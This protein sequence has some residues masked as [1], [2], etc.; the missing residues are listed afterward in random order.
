MSCTGNT[1]KWDVRATHLA[2]V[3]GGVIIKQQALLAVD[4]SLASRCR[5]HSFCLMQ[6]AV[7][8]RKVAVEDT[9]IKFP[10][11]AT[12]NFFK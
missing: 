11:P 4:I 5:D 6:Y 12:F 2:N 7:S 3:V 8:D 1:N 10:C 9:R